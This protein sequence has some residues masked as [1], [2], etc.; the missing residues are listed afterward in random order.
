MSLVLIERPVDRVGVIRLNRP[1][2]RN[3]LST[4]FRAE[5]AKALTELD[6]D[7]GIRCIVMTGD[8]KAFAAGAD[9]AELAEVRPMQEVF[10]RLGAVKRALEAS[11]TPVIA[12]VRGMALGG[13]CEMAM[14]CDIIIAGDTAKFGQPEIKVGIM[15]GA[16]GTQK[17]LRTAGKAKALRY[18]LTGD[19]FPADVALDLGI[20]SEVVP[21]AEVMDTSLAMAKRIAAQPAKAVQ[22][23]RDAVREGANT[24][25]DTALMLENRLFQMLFSTDDQKEGM[26]AFLEKRAPEFKGQ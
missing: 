12:A 7:P 16:G 26:R 3:A 17:I 14:M 20:V 21:D 23:I 2:R 22:A 24:P 8:E 15:P 4:E 18:L 6:A 5:I 9:L 13:G 11:N 19:L 10:D 1:E 25:L